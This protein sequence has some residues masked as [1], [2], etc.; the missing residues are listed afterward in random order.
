MGGKGCPIILP[1]WRFYSRHYGS[2]ICRKST[3]W[4]RQLYFP[5]EG[6][7]AEDFFSPLYRTQI[8]AIFRGIFGIFFGISKFLFFPQFLPEPLM[9]LQHL[10]GRHCLQILAYSLFAVHTATEYHIFGVSDSKNPGQCL[11]TTIK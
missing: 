2:F 7:R 4:D 6:R 3:T 10:V 8:S 5:S 1:T 11:Y 9:I